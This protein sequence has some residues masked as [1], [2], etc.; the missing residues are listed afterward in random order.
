MKEFMSQPLH[1]MPYQ[2]FADLNLTFPGH[3][4]AEDYYR[5]L[6]I[7]EAVA[8]VEYKVD[9]VTF[10][11]EVFSS[12]VDQALVVRVTADKPGALSFSAS[13]ASPHKNGVTIV[14]E[15]K[16][17]LALTGKFSGAR[18]GVPNALS[19]AARVVAEADGGE[20]QVTEKGLEFVKV[21]KVTLKLVAATSFKNYQDVSGDPVAKCQAYLEQSQKKSYKALRKDH[22]ADHQK[23]FRRCVLDLGT[24]EAA[25]HPTD[26]RVEN[27]GDANDPQLV[28]L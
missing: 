24:T 28:T 17:G 15:G 18:E 5:E 6:D 10:R 22:V 3:E 14:P 26:E 25:Q 2:P 16:D 8:T 21:N 23:Y 11:R 9:G 27:F 19:F 7:D 12:A 13:L 4:K 20:V 1:Q